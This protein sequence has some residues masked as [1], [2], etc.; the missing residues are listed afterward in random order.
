MSGPSEVWSTEHQGEAP[1][2]KLPRASC[3]VRT[4]CAAAN[5]GVGKGLTGELQPL[6]S[7]AIVT[8][9]T[10][11]LSATR[12]AHLSFVLQQNSVPQIHKL[13]C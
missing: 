2:A 9:G 6:V 12:G 7:P 10:G 3:E 8:T 4:P 1:S 13:Q 5:T 11:A